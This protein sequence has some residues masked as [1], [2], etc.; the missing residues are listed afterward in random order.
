M[1]FTVEHFLKDAKH[2]LK[3]W[4]KDIAAI[5]SG[6][7]EYDNSMTKSSINALCYSKVRTYNDVI[8]YLETLP[9][10]LVIQTNRGLTAEGC[11]Y[12]ELVNKLT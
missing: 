3:I 12:Y 8:K 4:E 6:T 10:D 9:S 5:E 2:M 1:N 7:Y 11:K